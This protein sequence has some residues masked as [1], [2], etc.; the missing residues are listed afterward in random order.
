MAKGVALFSRRPYA[1]I[2][3]IS[4]FFATTAFANTLFRDINKEYLLFKGDLK[5][6]KYR[7]NYEKL[8]VKFNLFVKKNP[9]DENAP[10]ALLNAARL[11]EDIASI[12][13]S[14]D[15]FSAAKRAYLVVIGHYEKSLV[16]DEALFRAVGIILEIYKDNPGAVKLLEQFLSSDDANLKLYKRSHVLLNKLKS[17]MQPHSS[18]KSSVSEEILTQSIIKG[19][20]F[21]KTAENSQIIVEGFSKNRFSQGEIKM[22]KDF[23][24]RIFFDL[25][26]AKLDKNLPDEISVNDPDIFKIRVGKPKSD[27]VRI[28]VELS[29]NVKVEVNPG[30]DKMIL[31]FSIPDN[32]EIRVVGP[33]NAVT[34][35]LI[36]KAD[37]YKPKIIVLDPGHGGDDPGAIGARGLREKNVTLQIAQLI[38]SR[39]EKEMPNAKVYMTRNRDQTLSLSKRTEIA[40]K[41]EADLFIS[42]H[43]N[44]APNRHAQGIETYYLN[45]S[46][47]RYAIRLAALEN[48]MSETEVSNLE[49][50]LADLAMKNNVSDSIRL[51]N[52]VQ[53]SMFSKVREKWRDTKDLGLKHALF[54]VLLG[55]KM[56]AILIE[57]SFIS[58][59]VEEKRLKSSVYQR[60]LAQGVVKGIKGYFEERQAM[61][62]P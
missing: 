10:V 16:V 4:M 59:R 46:H 45:I 32:S 3:L 31:N 44:A 51:G 55:T 22:N 29:E 61:N 23:P 50:I 39:L 58:N 1:L 28:V 57:T 33:T 47:D 42:I 54:F 40:N 12:T 43:A 37:A 17:D 9:K 25:L 14:K 13:R 18:K 11:S 34:P 53:S 56:P 60:A 19:V 36:K 27:V 48:S 24:R 41:L 15:D 62:F 5:A 35:R 2:L 38:K 21:H 20:S 6:Q 30:E 8:I 7:H 26:S 49:F 52:I